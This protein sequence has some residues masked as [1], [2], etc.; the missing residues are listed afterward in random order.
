MSA[1]G[2]LAIWHD[3]V[4]GREAEFEAWYQ[5]EHLLERLAV[6][7]FLF[8]RRHEAVS[9]TPRYF[10]MYVGETPAVFT[11]AAYLARLNDP[12]PLTKKVMIEMFRD[13]NRT[14]CRRVARAGAH[15]GSVAVTLRFGA[16]PDRAAPDRAAT[17]ALMEA[18]VQD[19]AVAGAEY[20]EAG[21]AGA[22][23]A[24]E[25]ERL[26]GGDKKIAAC[27]MIDMMREGEAADVAA[28]LARRFPDAEAGVYR[29]LCTL[30]RS[31]A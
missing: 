8:G 6:P 3:C 21:A 14:V 13:M 24:A 25:E 16:A 12:T 31:D 5:G 4:R 26:R 19:P 29:V 28:D 2:I 1:D 20:W 22:P 11:S 27:L 7:G 9:G 15:R 10:M 30:G 17:M 23:A 18:L